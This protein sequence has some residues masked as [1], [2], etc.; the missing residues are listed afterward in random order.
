MS[1]RS[2]RL[3]LNDIRQACLVIEEFA[4]GKTLLDYEADRL[5]RSGIERQL[6]IIGEAMRAVI[7]F[8]P[9][10]AGRLP[11]SSRIIGFRNVLVHHYFE[12]EDEVVW[13]IVARRVPELLV[14]VDELLK[15]RSV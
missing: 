7:R 12:I 8:D 13:I 1:P 10:L 2:L 15:D 5:L 11:E 9:S 6:T 14:V 3:Y 4:A